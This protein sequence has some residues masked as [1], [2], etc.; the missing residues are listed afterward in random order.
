MEDCIF[1]KIVAGEIPS[2]K[3][4]EDDNFL[5]FL[6]VKPL[7]PG[8]TLLIPKKHTEYIFDL[9]DK[10]F[11]ELLLKGK[12]ISIIL[13][14]KLNSKKI[15]LVVEG[16]SVPHIHVHLI[17][18]DREGQL[19]PKRAISTSGEELQKIAEKIKA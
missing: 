3:I 15:G 12:E 6:D 9:G 13:K 17:P 16:F 19:D 18:L 8:H 7:N 5:S 2:V 11:S 14:N 10:E 4:F 1:C